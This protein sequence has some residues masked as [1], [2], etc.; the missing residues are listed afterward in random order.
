MTMGILPLLALAFGLT[1]DNFRSA[2]AIGTVP[3]GWRRAVQIALVFGLWDAVAPLVGGIA[4]H[5]LGETVIGR[6]ADYVGPVVLGLYG[7]F[8]V[9]QAIRKPEPDEID[10]PWVTLFGMPLSLSLDNLL[11]GATLGI[12]GISLVI[13]VVTF[14]AMTAIMTLAGLVVGRF[15]A[16]A[17]KIRSD[18]VGGISLLLAAVLIPVMA[19]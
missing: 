10:H 12:V 4:G 14:G 15:A 9:F 16:K 18:L 8:L 13:P 6:S 7:A 1:L 2:I 3:F 5:Y 11:A 17:I 19:N